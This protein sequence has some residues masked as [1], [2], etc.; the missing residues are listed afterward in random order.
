VIR[1]DCRRARALAWPRN[2]T[3]KV[4]L[5]LAVAKAAKR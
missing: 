1:I 3:V 5:I 4:T 2:V